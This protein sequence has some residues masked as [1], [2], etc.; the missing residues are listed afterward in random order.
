MK[1]N[2]V[3]KGFLAFGF[4]LFFGLAAFA[5][6]D[7]ENV[8]SMFI[9]HFIKYIEWPATSS[10]GDFVIGVTGNDALFKEIESKLNGKPRPG[11]KIVV[12]KINS[13]SQVNGLQIVVLG[14]DGTKDF[15]NYKAQTA[16]KPILLITEERGLGKRGSSINFIV[17]NGKLKFE[18]NKSV[19]DAQKLRVS[20]SLTQVA[21]MI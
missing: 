9:H 1:M 8:Q 3:K 17:V 21:V 13:A 7:L 20:S 10:N 2:G 4:T 16:G 18:L 6:G 15:D 14:K 12:R 5:Q 19:I 11:G